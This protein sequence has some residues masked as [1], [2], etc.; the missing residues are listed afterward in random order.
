[1]SS[2]VTLVQVVEVP[3]ASQFQ[4]RTTMQVVQQ[5]QEQV[6]TTDHLVHIV[7]LHSFYQKPKDFEPLQQWPNAALQKAIVAHIE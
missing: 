5:E 2:K 1:M 3:F 4:H 6:P 7:M